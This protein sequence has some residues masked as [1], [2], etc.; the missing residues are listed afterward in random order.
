MLLES[1]GQLRTKSLSLGEYIRTNYYDLVAL[2]E[3]WLGSTVDKKCI[4]E[5][6]PASYS[7]KHV[8]P[9]EGR[10]GGGL[11]LL[12]KSALDVRLLSSSTGVHYK[13]V[14]CEHSIENQRVRLAVVY[15]PPPSQ[16]H[17]LTTSAFLDEWST[18]LTDY[19][20]D[21]R[22]VLVVG[23]FNFNLDVDTDSHA[24]CFLDALKAC[25]F[26]QHVREPT[27]IHGHTLAV[28]ISRDTND[29]VSDATF[30][31]PVLCDQLGKASRD[32]FD[33]SFTTNLPKPVPIRKLVSYRKFSKIDMEAF[34]QDI[35]NSPLLGS[36]S[37][38]MDTLFNAYNDGIYNDG[39]S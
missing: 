26:Q 3:N 20:I 25:G 23:D 9:P 31:D 39:T 19:A 24:Q 8:P 16:Q 6:V 28:V 13:L 32:H 14:K 33:V 29:V 34:R 7:I 37:G 22:E 18:F 11:A 15:R 35:T 1:P 4:S 30:T 21:R 38:S 10:R 17:G 2:T 27:H 5:F 36:T 12:Y